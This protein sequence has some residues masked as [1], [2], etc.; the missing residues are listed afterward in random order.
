MNF[1][2]RAIWAPC[3]ALLAVSA[4]VAWTTLRQTSSTPVASLE[5]AALNSG[6][7]L[8][9]VDV[10]CF[11]TP[12]G[13]SVSPNVLRPIDY[14]CAYRDRTTGMWSLTGIWVAGGQITGSTGSTQL[15]GRSCLSARSC[16]FDRL[17][18]IEPI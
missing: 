18:V 12:A 3:A 2:R 17:D 8:R 14:A 9:Y 15:P 1:R 16:L 11:P 4:L 13:Y 7:Q 6:E 5:R 10:T